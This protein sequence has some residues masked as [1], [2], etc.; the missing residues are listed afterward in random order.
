MTKGDHPLLGRVLV[1][2]IW[3]HHFGR[4][5]VDT[6]GDFG[7]LGQRPSHPELLD[8]LATELV[9]QGWSMKRIHKLIMTSTV[10]RQ[11]SRRTLAQDAIDS[12]NAAAGS[13]PGAASRRGS[14]A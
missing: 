14:L 4:G 8:W 11:S 10:Y 7:M 3:L 6:P 5:I 13:L 1:N 9:R 12:G 2:R